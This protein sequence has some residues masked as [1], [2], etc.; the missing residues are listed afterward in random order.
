VA[1]IQAGLILVTSSLHP[2]YILVTGSL[3]PRYILVT[4]SLHPRYIFV[5][6]SLHP[7][8]ILVTSSLHIRYILVTFLHPQLARG[9]CPTR[10][11][12]QRCRP[13]TN[14]LRR[15][16]QY[17]RYCRLIAALS[18]RPSAQVLAVSRALCD[19]AA[20]SSTIPRSSR[21]WPRPA[22]LRSW[23]HMHKLYRFGRSHKTK[24]K[25]ASLISGP[26]TWFQDTHLSCFLAAPLLHP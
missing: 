22:S 2:R 3:R 4:S 16:T 23:A 24:G 25:L 8:Y 18:C 1:P 20:C 5:A 9:S 13:R 7:R 10:L 21:C 19:A 6:S 11:V 26:R 12:N 15:L 17:C 14:R